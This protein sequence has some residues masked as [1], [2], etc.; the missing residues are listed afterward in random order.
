MN[1]QLKKMSKDITPSL[2][3]LITLAS[4]VELELDNPAIKE[5][6]EQADGLVK[7][8]CWLNIKGSTFE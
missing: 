1:T 5:I 3:E 4:V 6:I 2:M 7:S 8:L